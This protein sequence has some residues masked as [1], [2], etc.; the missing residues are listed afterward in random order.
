MA[1]D[2]TKGLIKELLPSG[3]LDSDTALVFSNALYFKGACMSMQAQRFSP[4]KW[5]DYSSSLHDQQER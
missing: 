5:P 2:A 4:S 1:E 3:S